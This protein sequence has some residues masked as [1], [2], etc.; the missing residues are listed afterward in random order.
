MSIEDIQPE[1]GW[2]PIA[3]D[4]AEAFCTRK[5]P[6]T[7]MQVLWVI[8][9]ETYGWEKN[10]VTISA[11]IPMSRF[12]SLTR[13][14]AKRVCRALQWLQEKKIIERRDP[15]SQK[16]EL[17]T[18]PKKRP[19]NSQNTEF[20]FLKMGIPVPKIGNSFSD[21]GNSTKGLRAPKEILKKERKERNNSLFKNNS[22]LKK[23]NGR[24]EPSSFDEM[25]D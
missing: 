14:P 23:R 5:I 10:R 3:N 17:S 4:L 13:L 19:Y 15:N 8:L 2:M 20:K 12:T 6:P 9:R 16:G 22:Y 7:A 18:I 21:N 24:L 25:E 11:I 1:N